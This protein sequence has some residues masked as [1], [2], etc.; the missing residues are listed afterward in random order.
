[1]NWQDY[2][3]NALSAINLGQSD[4]AVELLQQ[5]LALAPANSGEY[6]SICGSLGKLHFERR[7]LDQSAACFEKLAFLDAENPSYPLTLGYIYFQQ[8]KYRQAIT[9]LLRANALAPETPDILLYLAESF[10]LTGRHEES[11]PFYQSLLPYGK[12]YPQGI[13]GYGQALLSTG[14]LPDG[15]DALEFRK[16]CTLGTW[17]RHHLPDWD[18]SPAPDKTIVAYA[19]GSIAEQLM[20]ATVLEDMIGNVGACILECDDSLHTLFRRSFPDACVVQLPK[21]DVQEGIIFAGEHPVKNE[22]FSTKIDAQVAMGCLPRLFRRSITA[23]PRKQA[24]LRP[25][26]EKVAKWENRLK[27]FGDVLKIGILWQGN[28]SEEPLP[29]RGIPLETMRNLLCPRPSPYRVEMPHLKHADRHGA[30]P[31]RVSPVTLRRERV[32]WFSLQNGS[33]QAQ[34][35]TVIQNQWHVKNISAFSE[36]F[37][38]DLDEMA[39]FLSALNLVIT[40]P[41]YVAHLAAG[42]GVP[43]WVLLPNLCDWRWRMGGVQSDWYA[44]MRLFRQ[45]HT[46]TWAGFMNKV[47]SSLEFYLSKYYSMPIIADEDLIEEY[48]LDPQEIAR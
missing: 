4:E 22:F 34:L 2:Y 14:R 7:E 27:D 8:K 32:H 36:I 30:D 21:A 13:Y 10:R 43:T 11:I 24:I 19:E 23:F 46:E 20:Y 40:P 45:G 33:P 15:W 35:R 3:E 31:R 39:A 5:A 38:P 12:Q 18:G 47:E 29:E 17:D 44:S 42:L 28:W 6:A 26:D 41:G 16:A 37:Q 25:D 48:Q 9:P 1:M